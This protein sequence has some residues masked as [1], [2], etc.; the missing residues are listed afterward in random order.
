VG[1]TGSRRD[2]VALKIE[3]IGHLIRQQAKAVNHK[4]TAACFLLRKPIIHHQ[5][6]DFFRNAASGRTAA[7]ENYPLVADRRPGRGRG[8]DQRP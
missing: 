4:D 3:Q 1:N 2:E 6:N 5:R 8:G 7:K